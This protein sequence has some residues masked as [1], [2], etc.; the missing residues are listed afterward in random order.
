MAGV[1]KP[2]RGRPRLRHKSV[3]LGMKVSEAE[4][5]RIKHRAASS[6]KSATRYILDL[7]ER[8]TPEPKESYVRPSGKELMALPAEVRHRM[9][10]EQAKRAAPY[11]ANDP[12]LDFRADDPILEY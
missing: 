5:T 8:D 9:F 6:G 11:Y 7:V 1:T 12:G 10:E 2:T 3:W 4:R